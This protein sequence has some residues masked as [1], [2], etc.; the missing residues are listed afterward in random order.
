MEY[1]KLTK[2]KLEK[3]FKLDIDWDS[4]KCGYCPNENRVYKKGILEKESGKFKLVIN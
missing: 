1:G 4:E 3:L 2:E